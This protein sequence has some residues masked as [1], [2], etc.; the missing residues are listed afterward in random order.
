MSFWRPKP[1]SSGTVADL[2]NALERLTHGKD[3]SDSP[4]LKDADIDRS[5]VNA[6]LHYLR[7][8]AVDSAIHASLSGR[9]QELV[10]QV[11]WDRLKGSCMGTADANDPH[12][13]QA[14]RRT[15][16]YRGAIADPTSGGQS[17]QVGRLFA[18]LCDS[19]WNVFMWGAG[20][21]EF[22]ATELAAA[23][24]LRSTRIA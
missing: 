4:L 14:R 10:T 17:E 5:V 7:I 8:F 19:E 9:V 20:S 2:A 21:A 11:Y 23:V 16:T 18:K 22:T 15:E 12:F 3:A 6:E 1:K 24:L 13:E